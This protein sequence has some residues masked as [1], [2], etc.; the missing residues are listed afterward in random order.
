MIESLYSSTNYQASKALLD[1]VA[2]RHQ[3]LA[4]NLANLETP[5]YQRLDID[6]TFEARFEA[7]LHRGDVDGLRALEPDV[8]PEAGLTPI[9]PDGNTV[10]LERE[11]MQIEEN[12][13][14]YEMLTQFVSG[15]LKHLQTAITGRTT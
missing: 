8:R 11:L 5:G 6:P 14:R 1:T 15:S 2:V 3:V 13:L 12:A 7:L 4:G 9:R 10:S